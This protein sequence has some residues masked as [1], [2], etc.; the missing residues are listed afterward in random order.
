MLLPCGDDGVLQ[1]WGILASVLSARQRLLH[2]RWKNLCNST[3]SFNTFP[4]TALEIM[5]WL[6][7]ILLLNS[8]VSLSILILFSE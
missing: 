8:L 7:C 1:P 4:L 6:E 5:L 3:F 2:F